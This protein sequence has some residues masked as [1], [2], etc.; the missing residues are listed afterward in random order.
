MFLIV[1]ALIVAGSSAFV[2]WWFTSLSGLPD[3][4]DPFDLAAFDG[5]PIPDDQNAFVLYKQAVEKLVQEPADMTYSWSAAGPVEKGWLA[6]NREAL[7]LWRRG[8]ERPGSLYVSPRSMTLLT[9][10]PVVNE[11]RAFAR[12]ARLEAGRL[13]AEGDL[14]G[15]RQWYRAIFRSSRHVG[16]R[17]T[18]IE[19]LVSMQM[20]RQAC[21]ELTRWAK[22][23][24][25]DAGL[26][27]RALDA[28]IADYEA[29][30]PPSDNLKVAYL[31]IL[32]TLD[33]RDLMRKCLNDIE[34]AGPGHSAWFARHAR[35]FGLVASFRKE[36]ERSRRVVRLIFAN[37]LATSDLPPD[38][39]PP[40]AC[41]LLDPSS[42]PKATVLLDLHALDDS[43][44][45][46]A[47]ALPPDK[48]LEWFNTTL[49]ASR[50]MPA[51]STIDRS[52][53]AER[54]TQAGTVIA[55]AGRLFE[56]EHGRLPEKDED[57]V[58]PY[59]RSLP[60]GYRPAR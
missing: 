13:E 26:I 51:F 9:Q 29:T 33:D 60:E 20:H 5:A 48:I 59:L 39:R 12:L 38:R 40:A 1:G 44:P 45:A 58:G 30:G 25:V 8:T 50:L 3:I 22:D 11:I 52:L 31:A 32:K 41:S 55:L 23:P 21:R 18:M 2:T 46:S 17:A 28:V 10:L 7:D 43:A 16:R 37:L 53:E 14:E 27:K 6:R 57:L 15:A 56:I 54:A 49:C 47:R 34:A 35:V 36:P 24:R 4:G 19:R 42:A